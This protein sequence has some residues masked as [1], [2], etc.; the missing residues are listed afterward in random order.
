M[1][2]FHFPHLFYYTSLHCALSV[3]S[4]SASTCAALILTTFAFQGA[5]GTPINTWQ[6]GPQV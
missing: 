4:V 1:C 2:Y 5:P 3:Y 6:P